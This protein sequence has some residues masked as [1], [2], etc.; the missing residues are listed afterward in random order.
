MGW[1]FPWASSNDI[2]F[3]FDFDVSLTEEQQ[4]SGSDYNFSEQPAQSLVEPPADSPIAAWAAT[5]GTDWLTY[6]RERPG[7]SAFALEDGVVYHTYSAFA[8]G[9]DGL[10]GM[11]QWLD[12]APQGRNEER[13][14]AIPSTS[15]VGT[16]STAATETSRLSVRVGCLASYFWEARTSV[17]RSPCAAP[18]P[19]RHRLGHAGRTRRP[20][21]SAGTGDRAR[22]RTP[23]SR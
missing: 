23:S 7:M 8:R 3:N 13:G 1:S 10:W 20:T 6:S 4:R 14:E 11:Y 5:A 15:T 2:D 21:A 16:T 19:D 18:E 22:R 9:L 12:R 17:N